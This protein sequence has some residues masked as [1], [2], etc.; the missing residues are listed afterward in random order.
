MRE[1][2]M[3][4]KLKSITTFLLTLAMVVGVFAYLP[5]KEAK[6][7]ET[8]TYTLTFTAETG[9]TIVSDNV[10]GEIKIDGEN[11]VVLK[12]GGTAIGTATVNS[13]SSATITV[14]NGPEG[15]L[16]FGSEA[17]DLYVGETKVTP[18]MVF[19]TDTTITVKNP[20]GNGSGS[21]V[22]EYWI[23]FDGTVSGK[24]VTFSGMDGVTLDIDSQYDI[25]GGVFKIPQADF[26]T[27]FKVTGF[28]GSSMQV[29]I[30]GSGNYNQVL[31]VNGEGYVSIP[32]EAHVPMGEPLHFNIETANGGGNNNPDPQNPTNKNSGI[33][34]TYVTNETYT[35]LDN[36]VST[37]KNYESE[38]ADIA[39]NGYMLNPGDTSLAYFE[40]GT[41]KVTFTFSTLWHMRYWDRIVING[42]EY[43]VSDY[44]DYDDQTDWLNHYK[45]QIVGFDIPNVPL[46]DVYDITVKVGRQSGGHVANF[47]WTGDP[48]Q[49]DGPDYIGH[50]HLEMIGLQYTVGGVTYTY[51]ESDFA[52]EFYKDYV[53]YESDESLGYD[54]GS[55]VIPAGSKVTMRITPE[56]GY[57]VVASNMGAIQTTDSGVCEFTFTV[58]SGAA[59]F[60]A[61]VKY[62]GNDVKA[63]SEKVAGG[64]VTLASGSLST[65]T[66]RLTVSDV[67]LSNDKI[68]NFKAAAGDYD[69]STYV[70]IDL[71]QVFYRGSAD[72]VWSN[73]IHRLNDY[74]TITLKLEDGITADDIVIVHNIDDG[75][76][77]EII[78][79]ESYDPATNTITFKTKSFSNYAI[80]TKTKA[81][82][83]TTTP[84]TVTTTPAATTTTTTTNNTSPKT[85]DDMMMFVVLLA[86]SAVGLGIMTKSGL[87][88]RLK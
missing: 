47:L 18:D 82:D 77:F 26:G 16:N 33:N 45:G 75:D 63:T 61:D 32:A 55:L 60:T 39:I 54:E 87:K 41:N 5:V 7:D 34:L 31:Q 67:E 72:S 27:A 37:T 83:T 88:K 17:F 74:A 49:A 12:S 46:A 76:E 1:K 8:Y 81:T 14:T 70:D 3:K 59:Y 50:A 78:E 10:T 6:A 43:K 9:H 71:D 13:A 58:G 11:Y 38:G 4:G 69:I 29:I 53:E 66:A 24:K 30:R 36:G 20:S 25:D 73:R 84:A 22:S 42:N 65:G 80:A 40:D 48:K 51:N 23:Q 79:I 86:M 35:Y 52:K 19:S 28:N 57:Q 21:N 64:D 44:L 15:K 56:Y 62:V 2:M 85:G 68:T